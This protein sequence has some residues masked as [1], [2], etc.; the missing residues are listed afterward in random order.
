MFATQRIKRFAIADDNQGHRDYFS[1]MISKVGTPIP[2]KDRF[3][4]VSD[5]VRQVVDAK[6]DAVICDFRLSEGNYAQG[7]DGA[8][9][10][11]A[12]FDKKIPTVL[13]TEY[14][15]ND[16]NGSIRRHRRKIPKLIPSSRATTR[17]IITGLEDCQRELKGDIPIWRRP[18]RSIVIIT[19][20]KPSGKLA[21]I[22]AL[23]PQWDSK[24]TVSFPRD[25]IKE[26]LWEQIK[27]DSLFIASVNI[28]AE[29]H[30]DLFFEDFEVAPMPEENT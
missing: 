26:S 23:V 20:I 9:V 17:A 18:R 3:A 13:T 16:V 27:I 14:T 30:E 8:D 19:D 6:A 15:Q 25:L 10:A 24:K 22:D 29:N 7:F 4:K 11:A 5:L 2:I 28:D 1:N 21:Q 12:L